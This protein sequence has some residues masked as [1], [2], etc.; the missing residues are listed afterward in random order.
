MSGDGRGTHGGDRQTDALSDFLRGVACGAAGAF[1]ALLA[2]GMAACAAIGLAA[3]LI[4]QQV[5]AVNFVVAL[6]GAFLASAIA[7]SAL[8]AIVRHIGR[9]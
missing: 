2:L 4:G 5:L 3:R 1:A 6:L 9:E 8:R 7:L